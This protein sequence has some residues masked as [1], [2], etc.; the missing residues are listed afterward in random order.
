M[1]CV[2]A[3]SQRGRRARDLRAALR[4]STP[5]EAA[6]LHGDGR[7]VRSQTH[8]DTYTWVPTAFL[9][10]SRS[11]NPPPPSPLPPAPPPPPPPPFEAGPNDKFNACQDTCTAVGEGEQFCRDGGKGSYS[12]ALCAYA[13]QVR[14]LE[15][16]T[17]RRRR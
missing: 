2:R 17:S 5:F 3:V 11:F 1:L 15:H 6:G 7:K 14:R 8:W 9:V 4:G 10:R 12:P 13:T 16:H